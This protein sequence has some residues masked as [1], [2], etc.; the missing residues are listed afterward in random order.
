MTSRP[1]GIAQFSR[2][3]MRGIC[4]GGADVIPGVSGGTV[5]LILG[6][7]QRL[8]TSI[9]HFDMSLLGLLR[10]RKWRDAAEH[11]DLGFL[12]ALGIGIVTG[13]LT[14]GWLIIDLLSSEA[15]R[16]PTWAAFFGMILAS[17]W[18]V[19]RYVEV[20]SRQQKAIALALAIVGA[21]GAYW[22]TTIPL[23]SNELT[24]GYLFLCGMLGICA[25]ILPGISGAY[26]LLILGVYVV[27]T[28]LI[29][30][31]PKDLL[32][33]NLALSD[34][35]TVLVFVSGCAVGLLAFSKLLRWLLTHYQP[36]TMAVMSGFMLGA[37]RKIWP[38]QQ[39]L[40]PDEAEFKLKQFD[41]IWPE[42][43][44]SHVMLCLSVALAGAVVVLAADRMTSSRRNPSEEK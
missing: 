20:D 23:G 8:V 32:Q 26:I 21:V 13:I 9:S 28:D 38:F 16:E 44:D 15:T 36:Y 33:G 41:P 42:A 18:L 25:M 30:S 39:D 6:I 37:L 35:G 2:Q 1:N 22:L 12:V 29:K 40:T 34:I 19:S 7:Y 31:L 10:Q 5:A 27:L 11:V 43:L 4:M 24:P 17:T 14:A 3:V